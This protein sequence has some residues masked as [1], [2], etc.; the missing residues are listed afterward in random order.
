MSHVAGSIVAAFGRHYEVELDNGATVTGFPLGKK[1]PY[2][3]GDRV[4]LAL[5]ASDQGQIL[6]HQPRSSLLYRSDAYREKLIAANA[7]QLIVVVATEPAFSDE[8]LSRALVAAEHER[9]RVLIVLNKCDLARQLPH[10]RAMLTPYADM[11]YAII[12]LSAKLDVAPLRPWLAGQVSV[13]VGQSGMGKSTLINALLPGAL[14]ATRE[15]STAL[16][17]GKHTTTHA[18]RYRLDGESSIIDCPGLQEFGLGHLSQAEIEAGFVE[19]RPW[20]GRCRFRD[21][22]HAAEPDCALKNAVAAG[23]V[24]ARR[25]EIFRRILGGASPA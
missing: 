12:E 13:L 1:S 2:A 14:A 8:L 5:S 17:S 20:L 15:I 22:H 25:L 9:L 6:R 21:C 24:S 3:C 10:A 4:E 19:F 23:T 18:R 11:G 16:N 7:T